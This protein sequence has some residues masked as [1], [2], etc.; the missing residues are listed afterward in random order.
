MKFILKS[1]NYYKL[2]L[3]KIEEVQVDLL[4]PVELVK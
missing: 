1:T 3:L 4:S 2:E